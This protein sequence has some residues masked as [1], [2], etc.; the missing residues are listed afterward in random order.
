MTPAANEPVV[1][2]TSNRIHLGDGST[3]GG[4]PHINASDAQNQTFTYPAVSGTGDAIVLTNTQPKGSLIAGQKGT[5]KA[6]ANNTTAVTINE[7]GIGT[8]SL[9]KMH[10]GA[11]VAL[12]ANDLV[13]GGLYDYIWDG[14]QY[15]VKG[16]AEGPFVSGGLVLLGSAT[17]SSSSTIDLTS[18]LSSTY[19]DYEIHL[20]NILP[21]GASASLQMLCS[22]DNS[23]FDTGVSY[24]YSI[25]QAST[26]STSVNV[27]KSVSGTSFTLTS[28]LNNF[29]GG[30]VSGRIN[31][32]GAN[33]ASSYKAV[34]AELTFLNNSGDYEQD[35]IAG[36]WINTSNSL[37]AVRFQM[38]SGNIVSGKFRIYGISKS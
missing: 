23:T 21:F 24:P 38:S 19:D 5:F 14:T 4:I 26:G 3:A 9:K 7:D 8:E 32:Y 37:E 1:N 12:V 36:H 25:I 28:S 22:T 33:T 2:T 30:G 27:T 17:A 16:L 29:S 35:R 18:M 20:N 31:L 13:S 6:G 15:Q 11:I 34:I 10:N